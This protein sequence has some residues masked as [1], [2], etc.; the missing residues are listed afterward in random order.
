LNISLKY[1]NDVLVQRGFP[2]S[3]DHRGEHAAR[4]DHGCN[5]D[6]PPGR[7]A[8]FS[9]WLLAAVCSARLV[10]QGLSDLANLGGDD[11]NSLF[12][13]GG[14]VLPPNEIFGRDWPIGLAIG[15]SMLA[16]LLAIL[17]LA[18]VVG[19]LVG[20]NRRQECRVGLLRSKNPPPG[21]DP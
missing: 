8:P 5:V 17:P 16:Q 18:M 6:R 11:V 4:V 1:G 12:V 10:I 14:S 19:A 21:R 20:R 13:Q 7:H 2:D 15:S 3:I 9:L